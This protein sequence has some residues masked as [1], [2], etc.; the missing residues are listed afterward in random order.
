MAGPADCERDRLARVFGGYRSDP[1]RRRAWDAGNPGNTAIRDELAR[2]VL[3]VLAEGDPGGLLLD[4]GCGSGWW[5]ARLLAEGIAPARLVG[6]E[7]LGD[8]ADAAR[9]RAPGTRIAHSDIRS[10]PLQDRSCALVTLFTVL[11]GMATAA[12]VDAALAESRRVLAPGGAIA[13]WEP[14]VPTPNPDTRLIRLRDLR[15]GLGPGLRARS[16]TLAPPLAR[17]AGGAYGALAA[18]G[19]L[20]SHRLVI[21]RPV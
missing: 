7:L 14:R 9:E 1:R 15:R 13:V 21:A 8:R 6:V 17:R 10:L 3:A 20:R 12:D 16:I 11:S 4:A 19:P 5:P 18:L 2:A